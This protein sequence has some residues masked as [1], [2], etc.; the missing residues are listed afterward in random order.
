MASPTLDQN[1][2]KDVCTKHIKLKPQIPESVRE[3]L[4]SSPLISIVSTDPAT[5]HF[6]SYNYEH[7]EIENQF[8][9][10]KLHSAEDSYQDF[11]CEFKELHSPSRPEHECHNDQ[12]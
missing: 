3:H 9:F 6:D 11:I 2:I 8:S 12:A 7:S 10:S 1:S 5:N 4:L